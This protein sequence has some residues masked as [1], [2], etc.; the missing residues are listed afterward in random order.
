MKIEGMQGSTQK[1]KVLATLFPAIIE[2]GMDRMSM[3]KAQIEEGVVLRS[4]VLP[5]KSYE[6]PAT[7]QNSH[8]E[9]L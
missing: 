2:V 3:S 8:L 1:C 7:R 5:Q 4:L 6:Q 9:D